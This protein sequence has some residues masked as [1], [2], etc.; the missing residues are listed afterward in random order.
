[1]PRYAVG[2]VVFV[3]VGGI[4]GDAETP[5]PPSRSYAATFMTVVVDRPFVRPAREIVATWRLSTSR[6]ASVRL[7]DRIIGRKHP[8][9]TNNKTE[10]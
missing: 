5:S 2:A 9:S 8:L 3:A 4:V 6:G 7:S 1:M 10:L